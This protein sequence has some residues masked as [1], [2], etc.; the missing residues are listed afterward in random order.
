MHP[1]ITCDYLNHQLDNNRQPS[2]GIDLPISVTASAA[3]SPAILA[4]TSMPLP[5]DQPNKAMSY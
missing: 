1:I 4:A 3:I 2:L 5:F